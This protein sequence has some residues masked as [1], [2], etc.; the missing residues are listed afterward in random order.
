MI[1]K[2]MNK[3]ECLRNINK[4]IIEDEKLLVDYVKL[5]NINVDEIYNG[6]V[7]H[8]VPAFPDVVKFKLEI[9]YDPEIEYYN[10]ILLQIIKDYNSNDVD[11]LDKIFD[12]WYVNLSYE[13]INNFTYDIYYI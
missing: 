6:L 2:Q 1:D 11:K 10:T 7:D 4:L 8:I 9:I 13:F 12:K 3:I 5:H